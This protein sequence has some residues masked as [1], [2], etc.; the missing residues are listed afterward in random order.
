[1]DRKI[2][3]DQT[4]QAVCDRHR[5]QIGRQGRERDVLNLRR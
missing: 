3:A 1:M 5:R 2:R 4:L